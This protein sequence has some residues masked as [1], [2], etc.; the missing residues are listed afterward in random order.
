MQWMDLCRGILPGGIR[1]RSEQPFYQDRDFFRRPSG[2]E[3]YQYPA[4]EN[5]RSDLSN[6]GVAYQRRLDP[7]PD[8]V[9][10]V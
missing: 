7:E 3:N 2:V 4:G 6:A 1:L 10:A 5:I 8:R 9:T